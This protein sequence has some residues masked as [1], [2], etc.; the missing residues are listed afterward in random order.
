MKG[1]RV[2]VIDGESDELLYVG[3][4]A[5]YPGAEFVG[6][7]LVDHC[8]KRARKLLVSVGGNVVGEHPR[9][10]GDRPAEIAVKGLFVEIRYSCFVVERSIELDGQ[11][12][13]PIVNGPVDQQLPA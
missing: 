4:A 5:G 10:I 3:L 1:L 6:E 9:Q 12:A 7:G 13:D 11:V 8:Q 2:V